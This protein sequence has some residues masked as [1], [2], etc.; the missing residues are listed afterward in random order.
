MGGV[1]EHWV[2]IE[3]QIILDHA[4][5]DLPGHLALGHFMLWQILGGEAGAV[6]GGREGVTNIAGAQVELRHAV[7][8]GLVDLIVLGD[9][10]E[11]DHD[12]GVVCELR[13]SM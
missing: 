4:V 12:C 7:D 9:G 13:G 1:L 8:E 3:G 10:G 2:T 6:D 11:V 5:G